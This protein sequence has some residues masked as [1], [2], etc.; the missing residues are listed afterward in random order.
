[1]LDWRSLCL[2]SD[3]DLHR[4]DVGAV[5]LAC[6]VGLPG[7]DRIDEHRCVG[8]LDMA[9]DYTG[10]YTERAFY[11][12]LEL[13]SAYG[14]SA[15]YFR[16]LCLITALQR[17]LR[18]RY[19]A[20][21]IPDD[22]PLDTA[23]TFIHGAIQG[24]GGTCASL[25]VVYAAVGRRLGYPIR[26]VQSP[27]HFFARW[28][29]EGDRFNIETTGRGLTCWTDDEYRHGK[30]RASPIQEK[31]GRLYASQTPREEVAGFL[32]QRAFRWQE[33]GDH[34]EASESFLHAAILARP[35]GN[36]LHGSCT[37]D[38]LRRWGGALREALPPFFPTLLIHFPQR[39]FP[40]VP[41]SVEREYITWEVVE[42]CLHEPCHEREW[43][44]PQRRDPGCRPPTLPD[45]LE[46]AVTA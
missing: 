34:H 26:L 35:A 19:N 40:G 5:N 6:A 27:C 33:F 43:W 41:A 13:P 7:A 20:A 23:D 8:W 25:P 22:I 38:A 29:G 44:A 24:D 2:L 1:M 30:H 39:R 36:R 3:G 16:V 12:F 31:D 17:D 45:C 37:V 42:H 9:A 18:L 32:A 46:V 11:R 14:H 28:E 4:L 21:K 15:G 10:R